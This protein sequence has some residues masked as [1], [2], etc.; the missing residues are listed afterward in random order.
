MTHDLF[1]PALDPEQ[2]R[3]RVRAWLNSHAPESLRHTASTPFQGHWGGRANEFT[4]DDERS[5]FQSCLALGLTAPGWPKQYGGAE[6]NQAQQRVW[7]EEL[8][9]LGMPQPLVGFGLT[10]IGPILLAEGT[11]AQKQEHLPRIVRGEIRWC[12]GYSEP[13]AGSDLASLRTRGVIDGDELVING[14]KTWTS[15]A[16][17]SDWI[18]CLV[19]TDP[20]ARQQ[21]GISFV[22]IDMRTPGITVRPIELISGAS[23]FCET[24]FEDVRVPLS[25]VVGHL[26][27]GWTVAKSLL[28]HERG[29][30]GESIAAG[31]ARPKVL[32]SYTLREHALEVVGTGPDGRLT[33][34]VLRD[35]I[36]R[37]EM[38]QEAMR[39]TL[40]RA[41]DKVRAGE[42]PGPESSIFKVLGTELN[43]RR[44]ELA[45]HIAGLDGLGWSTGFSER[46]RHLATHWLRSRGNTIEGGTS[47]VQRNIIARHVL[48]LPKGS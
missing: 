44:W 7:K 46:D 36:A 25:H 14:Q 31:G 2:L 11:E 16:E 4:S 29:M 20:T 47:E 33:D 10:M 24:F 48:G 5:W 42:A 32:D 22:L 19:R 27:R 21:E 9:A 17:L 12:Q 18:F 28:S 35:R 3:L 13:D 41:N 30:V 6:L 43:Q 38:E 37:S 45:T 34:P 1:D 8:L 40:R 15:H 23:P 26:H 39:L